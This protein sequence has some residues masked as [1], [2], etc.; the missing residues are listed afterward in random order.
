MGVTT[1]GKHGR[2][3]RSIIAVLCERCRD[4][5]YAEMTDHPL[6]LIAPGAASN[7]ATEAEADAS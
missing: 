4:A 2:S 5:G 6:P 1:R 3:A 7:S